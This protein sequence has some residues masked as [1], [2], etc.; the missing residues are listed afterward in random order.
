[1]SLHDAI[2]SDD[3]IKA[4]RLI[5]RRADI[6]TFENGETPLM[7]AVLSPGKEYLTQLLFAAGAIVDLRNEIGETA[8]M[9]A[10]HSADN[11]E[12][13]AILIHG[14]ADVGLITR[15]GYEAC[16]YALKHSSYDW[17]FSGNAERR[18][19]KTML[20][21]ADLATVEMMCRKQVIDANL[22]RLSLLDAVYSEDIARVEMLLEMGAPTNCQSFY[23]W[24][25]L[26]QAACRA[27][28]ELVKLL[29]RYGADPSYQDHEGRSALSEMATCMP[30]LRMT[31]LIYCE[32]Y[33]EEVLGE[34]RLAEI[35][36]AQGEIERVINFITIVSN[37]LRFQRNPYQIANASYQISGWLRSALVSGLTS[38]HVISTT[39]VT[40]FACPSSRPGHSPSP[41][42]GRT[43][44]SP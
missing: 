26:M 2:I 34:E 29:L 32:D 31:E 5:R 28:L 12:N 36:A 27:H 8:F 19:A 37:P 13:V 25:A 41:C 11:Q 4:R 33:A 15:Y 7:L 30:G 18:A 35:K 21:N 43:R 39:T 17:L 14:G 23:G 6:N 3:I 1:M 24:S 44:A 9:M 16:D 22:L 38:G 40:G 20:E 42:C 10:M